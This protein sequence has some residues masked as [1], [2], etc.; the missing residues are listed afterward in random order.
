[1]IE[2]NREPA[3]VGA[4]FEAAFRRFGAHLGSYLLWSAGFGAV[5][6]AIAIFAR[7]V[8]SGRVAFGLLFAGVCLS[9]FLLAGALT[10]LVTD[11]LRRR[12]LVL[13]VASLVGAAV[14]FAGALFIGPLI[15]VLYPVLVF[16][17]IAA[18]AGDASAIGAFPHG[19]RLALRGWGRAYGAL[20]GLGFC[21]FFLWLGFAVALTPV[22]GTAGQVAVL[23]LTV[24]IGSP[25]A[26]LVERN[27]YGD[28][29]GRNVLPADVPRQ[30][31]PH[32]RRA[33]R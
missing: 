31:E 8:G 4:L 9:H 32:A 29:T 6:A 16:A 18:A 26:A 1:M 22:L 13:A 15:G 33:G 3:S 24:L 7:A 30:R 25:V 10:A 5:A 17:P 27:L 28:M 11:T 21:F 2:A 23:V 12:A 19:A 14:M 20:F